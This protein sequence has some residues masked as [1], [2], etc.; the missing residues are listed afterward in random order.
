[1]REKG[2]RG[3]EKRSDAG[4][5]KEWGEGNNPRVCSEVRGGEGAEAWKGQGERKCLKAI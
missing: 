5:K 3:G 2:E 1:M 4:E